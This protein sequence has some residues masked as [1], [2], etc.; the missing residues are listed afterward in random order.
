MANKYT[1]LKNTKKEELCEYRTISQH[2]MSLRKR[3]IFRHAYFRGITDIKLFSF[4]VTHV[5]SDTMLF[6][7]K[8]HRVN[9]AT[10][11]K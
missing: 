4:G 11:R 1:G 8:G 2:L 3:I 9:E 10:N 6:M 5:H 7:V